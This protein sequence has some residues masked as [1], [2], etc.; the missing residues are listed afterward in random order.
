M[1]YDM[2]S[3]WEIKLTAKIPVTVPKIIY[4]IMP[5]VNQVF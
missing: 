1:F 4:S 5:K 3:H 2:K